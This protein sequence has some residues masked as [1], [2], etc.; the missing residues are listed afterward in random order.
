MR[1]VGIAVGVRI[2][3]MGTNASAGRLDAD[4]TKDTTVAQANIKTAAEK[5]NIELERPGCLLQTL[6][7]RGTRHPS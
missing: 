7:G 1:Q 3:D 5:R 2:T 4:S 6:R